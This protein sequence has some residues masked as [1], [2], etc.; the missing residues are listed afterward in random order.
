[1]FADA[2]YTL[3]IPVH[4]ELDAMDRVRHAL[5]LGELGFLDVAI[6]LAQTVTQGSRGSQ[7]YC[8]LIDWW[9]QDRRSWKRKAKD[10]GHSVFRLVGRILGE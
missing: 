10:W 9:E 7:V 8:R 3:S 2:Y 1:M 4:S 5:V 6:A